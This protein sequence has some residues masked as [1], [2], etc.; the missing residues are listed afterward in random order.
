MKV[1]ENYYTPTE[2]PKKRGKQSHYFH[3]PSVY[4]ILSQNDFH[5]ILGLAQLGTWCAYSRLRAKSCLNK[6]KG[7]VEFPAIHFEVKYYSE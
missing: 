6:N 3:S 7:G 4:C 1:S 2:T 5:F